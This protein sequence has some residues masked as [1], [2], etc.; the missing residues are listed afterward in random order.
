MGTVALG[1]AMVLLAT[2]ILPQF[3][4]SYRYCQAR[5]WQG[6]VGNVYT[7]CTNRYQDAFNTSFVDASSGTH[8]ENGATDP[9]TTD[10]ANAESFCLDCTTLGGYR[11]TMQGITLLVFVLAII[12]FGI[13]FI[14]KVRM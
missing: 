4:S 9:V 14:P 11:T 8:T 3:S 6:A 7:N 13:Y 2:L 12:G 10:N 5:T 1:V